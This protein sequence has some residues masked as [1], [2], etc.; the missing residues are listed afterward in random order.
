MVLERLNSQQFN[1]FRDFIYAQCGIR[2]DERKVTLLSNRIRRR[3]NAGDFN[4]FDDYYRFL[5]SRG[6]ALE[7]ESFIDAITTNETFFFRTE[8]HFQWLATDLL[9][10]LIA[11]HDAGKRSRS[12]RIWSAGCASG[13]EPYSIAIAV[14]ENQFRL[15]DWSIQIVGT[16]ISES[17]L[18]EAREGIFKSRA[19]EAVSEQRRR[20]FF[21]HSGTADGI[22]QVRPPIKESVEFA[23]HNLMRPMRGPAFDC[24]FIRNVL[25]YFD[26]ESKQ[27][28]LDHLIRALAVGGYLVVG[29]SEGVYDMLG[30]L[31]K[32]S[33]LIYRKDRDSRTHRQDVPSGETGR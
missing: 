17:V 29:P 9:D 25:I 20:R 15:R 11:Q 3:L 32:V 5:T 19:V 6:G 1:Q 13:A 7:L 4:D 31:Q 21:L 22:W 18:Q 23:R 16:D 14:A 12:L 30:D 33:P 28:V 2:I 8:K 24:I 10:E 26:R 27:V